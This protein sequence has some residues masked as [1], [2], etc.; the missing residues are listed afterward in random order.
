MYL[1][2]KKQRINSL[3]SS[4]QNSAIKYSDSDEPGQRSRLSERRYTQ[5]ESDMLGA[6]DISVHSSQEQ[7]TKGF[8]FEDIMPI[9]D[10][11]S[12][13][14]TGKHKRVHSQPNA[15]FVPPILLKHQRNMSSHHRK[16]SVYI[17]NDAKYADI[18][19]AL[20]ATQSANSKAPKAKKIS[21]FGDG[22]E[23]GDTLN[24]EPKVK[25]GHVR[26]I[27]DTDSVVYVSPDESIIFEKPN[28]ENLPHNPN[29]SRLKIP[30]RPSLT[31]QRKSK[32]L[33]GRDFQSPLS[34][35]L[36]TEYGS[37]MPLRNSRE[38]CMRGSL[39]TLGQMPCT[40]YCANCRTDVHTQIV[41][42]ERSNMP[43]GVLNFLNSVFTCCKLPGWLDS[44]REHRCPQCNMVVAKS[45]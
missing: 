4:N 35:K 12:T 18:L 24:T 38:I 36:P 26:Q 11:L 16:P 2:P 20:Q 5:C 15:A 44:Y 13:L 39:P 32:S 23:L 43:S 28:K 7:P 30:A 14:S 17:P 29:V 31:Q 9:Q 34:T 40:A 22:G 37:E 33:K 19:A 1:T 21:Y 27:S 25:R 41:F 42:S 45:R 8:K 3:N 10:R 6:L